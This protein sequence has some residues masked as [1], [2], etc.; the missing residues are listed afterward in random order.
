M[1]QEYVQGAAKAAV[2]PV[3]NF[4]APGVDVSSATGKYKSYDNKERFHIPDTR[5]SPGGR[6][7]I[8]NFHKGDQTYDCE[9]N[10]LDVPVEVQASGVEDARIQ[11]QEAADLG[12]QVGGLAHEKNVIDLAIAALS[13]SAKT[14]N[15]SADPV[16]DIDA[17]I[18]EVLKAANFGSLMRPRICFG[19]NAWE[20]FKNQANV[21]GRFVVSSSKGGSGV[22]VAVPTMENASTLFLGNPEL[23]ASFLVYD[24]AAEGVT[25]DLKFIMSNQILVFAAVQN[26]TRFDPS[27]MKTFRLRGKWMVP[28]SYMSE[29]GRSEVAKLDWS[30]DV[31]V[32]NSAAAKL[33]TVA[34]T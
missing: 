30:E 3:A 17:V 24:D 29:D 32:T 5:R 9:P 1:L 6:A 26:P 20:I 7:T 21:R 2:A 4:I 27:F 28:G 34:T 8:L 14:W 15:S 11:F 13:A 18:L 25:E 31:K 23:A 19:A 16:A 33:L 12:A 22:G 10:A